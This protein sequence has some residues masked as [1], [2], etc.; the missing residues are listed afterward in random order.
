MTA[1]EKL[2]LCERIVA[3]WLEDEIQGDTAMVS[4]TTVLYPGLMSDEQIIWE[5]TG[6]AHTLN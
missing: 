3:R 1:E 5:A 2:A 4:V 6:P